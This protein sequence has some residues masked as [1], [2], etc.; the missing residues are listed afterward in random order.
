[1]LSQQLCTLESVLCTLESHVTLKIPEKPQISLISEM[2][3]KRASELDN[4]PRETTQR[5]YSNRMEN[6]EKN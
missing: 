5:S 1:M 6:T 4:R 2:T 3:G